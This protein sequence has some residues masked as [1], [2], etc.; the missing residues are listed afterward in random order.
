MKEIT[1]TRKFDYN[2]I[3]LTDPG[4]GLSADAVREFYATQFPELTNAVVE[5]PFTKDGVS[6]Y[7]FARAAGAKGAGKAAPEKAAVRKALRDLVTSDAAT[8]GV[9]PESSRIA[10]RV[11]AVAASTAR[12]RAMHQPPEAFGIWG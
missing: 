9:V 1:I 11:Q 12:G 10:E 4:S 3:S 5:G 6:T 8:G 2:G 7:K